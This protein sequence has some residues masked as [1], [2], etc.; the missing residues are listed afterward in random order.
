MVQS[1]WFMLLCFGVLF[2]FEYIKNALED[3]LEEQGIKKK[4]GADLKEKAKSA[5]WVGSWMTVVALF[6]INEMLS[7]KM[8]K[9]SLQ[10]GHHT[11]TKM[12]ISEALKMTTAK[13]INGSLILVAL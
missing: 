11:Q 13:F 5:A 2:V 9:L 1:F 10:E 8:N 6:W 3:N 12:F 4:L 7:G